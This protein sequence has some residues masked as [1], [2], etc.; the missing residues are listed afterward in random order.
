MQSHPR[1][2]NVNEILYLVQVS[3]DKG[4]IVAVNGPFVCKGIKGS[5]PEDIVRGLTSL[6]LDAL[7]SSKPLLLSDLPKD[8]RDTVEAQLS[9]SQSES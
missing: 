2:L 6:L 4:N 5:E 7:H 3:Y 9:S 1:F 8:I